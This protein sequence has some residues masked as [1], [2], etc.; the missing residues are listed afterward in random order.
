[1]SERPI[2]CAHCQRPPK[3]VYKEIVGDTI[4]VT[5]M[6][7]IC[8]VLQQKLHGQ[9]Y[10]TKP[11][12]GPLESE[13]TLSCA[14]CGTTWQAVTMGGSLGCAECY[15][16]FADLL[17]AELIATDRAAPH[18]KRVPPGK[19]MQI[20]HVGKT[21]AA[22]TLLTPS[23]RLHELNEALN[24]AL[25]RENYEQAAYLRDQIQT[26]TGKRAPGHTGKPD[27]GKP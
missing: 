1:M 2:E 19:R 4:T 24:E 12:E 13:A 23:S 22:P 15:A 10:A 14:N 27:E 6:C 8:P 9:P 11:G 20:A 26:L 25:K 3:V 21:P 17:L 16:G 5:K 7:A 18:L